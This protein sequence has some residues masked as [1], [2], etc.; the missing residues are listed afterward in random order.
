VT[1]VVQAFLAAARTPING[2]RFNVGAGDPQSINR[3]VELLGGDV[4]H[5]PKRPGEPDC[6]FADITKAMSRLGWRPVVSFE[7]GVRRML[8]DIERWRDA[9]LWDPDRIAEATK[10]WFRYLGKQSA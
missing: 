8:V 6:T 3:L 5:V 9:P 10:T 7:D 4:V 2:E 1:D